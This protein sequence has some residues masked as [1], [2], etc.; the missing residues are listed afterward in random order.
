MN[1]W[2]CCNFSKTNPDCLNA[3]VGLFV[4]PCYKL[5]A[6]FC[7]MHFL[8]HRCTWIN[9]CTELHGNICCRYFEGRVERGLGWWLLALLTD[10]KIWKDCLGRKYCSLLWL[11]SDQKTNIQYWWWYHSVISEEIS[12]WIMWCVGYCWNILFYK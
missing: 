12:S 2:K 8:D 3:D 10:F 4:M 11:E 6:F 9:C 7:N 5:T 1:N